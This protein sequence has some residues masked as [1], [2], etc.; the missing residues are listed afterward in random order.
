MGDTLPATEADDSAAAR[1]LATR[2]D[3]DRLLTLLDRCLE[4]DWQIDRRAQLVLIVE[5]L[6]DVLSKSATVAAIP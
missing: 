2:A 3:P 4:A 1:E 6:L 5:A